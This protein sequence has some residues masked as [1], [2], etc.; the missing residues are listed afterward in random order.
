MEGL[1]FFNDIFEDIK[2]R[3]FGK[4]RIIRH[5]NEVQK[6]FKN[7]PEFVLGLV[8]PKLRKLLSDKLIKQGG[9]MVPIIAKSTCIGHYDVHLR[10]GINIM[11]SA[12]ISNNVY[13]G[14]G[15]LINAYVSIHHDVIIGDYCEVSPHAVILGG[16]NIG[17]FSSIGSN[18]AILPNI[19][20]GN[21]VI[22]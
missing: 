7:N 14:N 15:T 8:S 21:N 2:G 5:L 10:D 22:V 18:A 6:L 19:N 4:F 20:I 9:K 17:N 3:L 16:C 13:I 11:H 1:C 12:M